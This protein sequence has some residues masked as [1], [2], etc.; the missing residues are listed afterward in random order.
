ME[1]EEVRVLDPKTE[2][3][4]GVEDVAKVR[5]SDAEKAELELGE[6]VV[7]V[8]FFSYFLVL[9]LDRSSVEVRIDVELAGKSHSCH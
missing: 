6:I 5:E 4:E 7:V 3:T 9:L 1:V 8:L 2:P